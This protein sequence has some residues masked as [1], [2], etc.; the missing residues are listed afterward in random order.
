[1][2][3]KSTKREFIEWTILIVVVSTLYFTG[4]HTDVIGFIQRAA[5]STGLFKA[6]TEFETTKQASYDFILTDI[7]G[8]Q[9]AF[10]SFR[11]KTV[12]INFWATWCPPCIAEMPDINDLYLKTNKN[13]SFVMISVDEDREK[14]KKFM[15]RKGYDFP[16]Y[17]L[18][19]G[20]PSVYE[21]HSIPTTYVIAP[22]GTIAA[23]RH[24][25]AQ[26][27]SDEFRSFLMAL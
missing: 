7:N 2:A 3:K 16:I 24:G 27:D 11:E 4:Y 17:F 5:L 18:A 20:L 15:E 23:K 9:V 12:F 22:N 6:Q 1:M 26:Y 25:M 13:V 14:A 21:T 8:N 10:D 19:S